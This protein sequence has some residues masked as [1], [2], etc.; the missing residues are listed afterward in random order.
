M[1]FYKLNKSTRANMVQYEVHCTMLV[2]NTP[3]IIPT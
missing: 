3:A 1:F 2:Q